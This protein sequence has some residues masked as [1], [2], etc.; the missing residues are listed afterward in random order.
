MADTTTRTDRYLIIAEPYYTFNGS[1]QRYTTVDIS[2]VP[3]RGDVVE[4]IT[5]PDADGDVQA[6][7]ADGT[8]FDTARESLLSI[9]ALLALADEHGIPAVA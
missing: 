9:D 7:A 3:A 5:S 1:R 6:V 2:P 8:V 4:V